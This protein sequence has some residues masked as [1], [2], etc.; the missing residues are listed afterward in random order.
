MHFLAI[1]PVL[2]EVVSEHTNFA[3]CTM[4]V[5]ACILSPSSF[6]RGSTSDSVRAEAEQCVT[7]GCMLD[8]DN[9]HQIH[10]LSFN[11]FSR[12]T[13]RKSIA[14]AGF[15]GCI[16]VVMRLRARQRRVPLV[17]IYQ[18]AKKKD[19]RNASL[20]SGQGVVVGKHGRQTLTF[21]GP[22][23][24]LVTGATRSGKGV[25]HVVPTLLNWHESAVVYD[26][27]NELWPIT[28]GF[29]QTFTHCFYF[30]PTSPDSVHYNPL[31]E[32]RK[33]DREIRDVQNIVEMLVNPDGS[34]QQFDIWDQYASQLLTALILHVLY[35]ET[36]GNQHLGI[37]RSRLLD[38]GNTFSDMMQYPHRIDPTTGESVVHPE[39]QRVAND[40]LDQ[41]AKFQA[42]VRA[43]A[44][45]YLIL[46][47]DEVV[48]RNTSTSDFAIGDLVCSEH[49]A[50]LY[51]QP[52]PS[53]ASRLRPLIR[54][55]INQ[56]G[57]ALLENLETDSRGRKKRHRLLFLLD[58]FPTLGRLDFFTVNLRQMAGY[59]IKA[60]L[61]VQSFNDIIEQYG[62]HQTII[63]NCHIIVAFASSDTQTNQRISQMTGTAT[64]YR[65]SY[66]KPRRF[67]N[68]ATET[69]SQ[70]EQ[71]RPLLQ[72]GD[73]R[74]LPNTDQLIFVTGFPPMRTKKVVYYKERLFKQR[75]L[76]PPDQAA[77]LDVPN[78][79]F[80]HD[81]IREPESVDPPAIESPSPLPV[82]TERPSV[83]PPTSVPVVR[84]GTLAD[85]VANSDESDKEERHVQPAT[86]F[87]KIEPTPNPA[88]TPLSTP[89]PAPTTPTEPI[90]LDM[91]LFVDR[92][93][94]PYA[95]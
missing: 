66:S 90:D 84:P 82:P 63:D 50:T 87:D 60:H 83:P 46:F 15:I 33:G 79:E 53:D 72:P 37:V 62:P 7:L 91:P 76:D 13:R 94:D 89:E 39:I 65:D 54:L 22:E 2:L 45:G 44:A 31:L 57:R 93:D 71:V 61:I 24:Q 10:Y 59:G 68:L 43:T 80:R 17:G 4:F 55:M 18:W 49:P 5:F 73:V 36:D 47:A 1:R 40:M 20:L 77:H 38:F 41:P 70:S 35:T 16:W 88:P 58:E 42:S 64:E 48:C 67:L 78:R 29:R 12:Q 9:C 69:V 56:I 75:L 30:D 19:M 28:T 3:R 92:D 85:S 34:K 8:G 6:V 11:S 27:K 51:I 86:L 26:I 32:V 95:L 14:L 23:H 52:P 81:W 21:N 25:G 74:Q